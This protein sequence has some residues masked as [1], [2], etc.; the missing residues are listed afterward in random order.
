MSEQWAGGLIVWKMIIHLPGPDVWKNQ[1]SGF[2]TNKKQ[3]TKWTLN[4]M[5]H[6]LTCRRRI[7]VFFWISLNAWSSVHRGANNLFWLQTSSSDRVSPVMSKTRS[8]ACKLRR[9]SARGCGL[10][11]LLR[12]EFWGWEGCESH[13]CLL[14][15]ILRKTGLEGEDTR[16]GSR[17]HFRFQG[18]VSRGLRRVSS[19]EETSCLQW[20]AAPQR[21]EEALELEHAFFFFFLPFVLSAVNRHENVFDIPIPISFSILYWVSKICLTNYELCF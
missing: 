18:S 19:E 3:K 21:K 16:G 6:V 11:W 8:F 12:V 14:A 15:D 9:L 13:H 1:E 4:S 10:G 20:E 7:Y 5:L 17:W 2:V